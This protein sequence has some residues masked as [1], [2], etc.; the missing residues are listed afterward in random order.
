MLAGCRVR[1][2]HPRIR[3]LGAV[4]ELSAALGL[5]SVSASLEETK[6]FVA[7]VQRWLIVLMG[8]LATPA[9]GEQRHAGR[10]SERMDDAMITFL[11]DW[12]A[13]LEKDGCLHFDDWVLPGAAGVMSGAHADLAR[14]V[15]RRAERLVV[16]LEGTADALPDDRIMRFLNR[17]S[18]VLW[19]VARWEERH[20]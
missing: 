20:A 2:S 8:E 9:G 14:T 5:L 11:D 19:L 10:P 7:Q 6:T 13:R 3:A 12:G 17:L 1:K 18:D 16:A 15:C 4:D